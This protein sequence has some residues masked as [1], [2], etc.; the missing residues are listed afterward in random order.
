[1]LRQLNDELIEVKKKMLE[2]DRMKRLLEKSL[3]ELSELK[4]RREL[5]YESLEKE[6]KDLDRIEGLSLTN[7]IH[8]LLGDKKKCVEKERQ[9]FLLQKLKYDEVDHAIANLNVYIFEL[10]NHI[11]S[12]GHL[13]MDYKKIIN[14]KLELLKE[15]NN[16]AVKL[17]EISEEKSQLENFN[18]ELEEA[19]AA[20]AEVVRLLYSVE[21]S[22]QAAKGWGTW[23][24]LGG[25]L[26]V[27][28]AKHSKIDDAKAQ[29]NAVQS[30]LRKFQRELMD[31]REYIDFNIEIGSFATFAD[32]FFDG[33][34]FDF[35]V[36]QK[37]GES[38]ETVQEML[39]RINDII[40]RLR[41]KLQE[42]RKKLAEKEREKN[43]MIEEAL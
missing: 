22:L 12:M 13:D 6:K 27:T 18:R 4:K 7:L 2:R 17:I 5:L 14:R 37:I 23:D 38:L 30:M 25:G 16:F 33:L 19:E 29:M 24:L 42:T 26:I 21:E 41:Q 1:M 3:E 15:D 8:C 32:Y 28:M 11:H 34:I 35:V 36:Q 31:I 10:E 20:G 40:G 9:E 43:K 39:V